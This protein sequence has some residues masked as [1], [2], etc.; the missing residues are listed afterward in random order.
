MPPPLPDTVNTSGAYR[1]GAISALRPTASLIYTGGGGRL[2]GPFALSVSSNAMKD[3][4]SVLGLSTAL[5]CRSSE[6]SLRASVNTTPSV[7][8]RLYP[9]PL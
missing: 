9:P 5:W 1:R 7:L 6:G 8:P 4:V 2:H 3:Q